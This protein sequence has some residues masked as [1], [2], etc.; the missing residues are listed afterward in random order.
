MTGSSNSAAT[1]ERLL[2]PLDVGPVRVKNRI[3]FPAVLPNYAAFNK[4]TEQS[5]HYY[6]ARAQGGAG[7]IVTE[8]LV[9][10]PSTIAQ[11]S[12]ISLFDDANSAA[13]SRMA[14][15]VETEDCRFVGQL[16]HVGR[17]QLW[18]P[19]SSPVGVSAE[20]DAFSWTVPHVM[21][22]D[23]VRTIRDAFVDGAM[24]LKAAGFSGAELHGAHGYL[25]G[26]FLSPWSNTRDDGWGGGIDGRTR[27]V[28][29]IVDGIR[30]ACGAGF[31]VGLKMPGDEG[32]AGGIDPA[33]AGR[34]MA[35]LKLHGGI[36]YFAFSQ[37][38]FSLSLED[39]VPDM[40][41]KPG[42]FLDI[43]KGLKTVAGDT[44][45]MAVGRIRTAAEAEAALGDGAGDLIALGRSLVADANL[46]RKLVEGRGDDV[47][48]CTFCNVCWGEI[49][50][51]K[52]M[53]CIHN[54]YLATKGEANVSA[55][56]ITATGK[57]RVVVVGAGVAGLEAAAV[58]AERGHAVTLFAM[59][60]PAGGTGDTMPLGGAARLEAGLPG[61][62]ETALVFEH[63]RK[64][65]IAAGVQFE[66]AAAATVDG[67]AALQPDHVVLA[68]G[69][70]MRAPK[71]AVSEHGEDLRSFL[72]RGAIA[73]QAGT[74]VLFDQDHTAAT[75]AAADLIAQAYDRT[76]LVTPRVHLGR[77]VSYVSLIGVYRRL[78][79]ADVRIILAGVP[80]SAPAG[81]VVVR[82]A[83]T[84]RDEIVEDVM[85]FIWST[86]RQANDGLAAGL[87]GK[88]L[89][90]TLIGDAR[91]PRGMLAAIHEASAVAGVL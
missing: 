8:A 62:A 4:I 36:D 45:V 12:V 43:H 87:R 27:F 21:D 25:I 86:P 68:T 35:R 37:G 51:G 78:Y 60:R 64:R 58:A 17:Q 32:V 69:A 5:I 48:P 46:P 30:A 56:T 70:R 55:A 74:A 54:P 61:R 7:M 2:S 52:P 91:A 72:A 50:A 41:Y 83:F 22:D 3:V 73:K 77:A 9:V 14:E 23:D 47:R 1:Y 71:L 76:V 75:Y 19:V 63:Q 90:V 34:I 53:A 26:Q 10:H 38:N 6:Q 33:E 59:P 24:R 44:P 11:P 28:R 29:E 82:N 42:P 13:L 88:S 85:A 66:F 49:H 20:P 89:N 39:H 31:L 15:A 65:C 84:G 57:K 81:R 80:V 16:W 40:H 67:I 79:Q 18:N